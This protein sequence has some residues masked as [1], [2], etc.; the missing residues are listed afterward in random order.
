MALKAGFICIFSFFR[1]FY[2]THSPNIYRLVKSLKKSSVF[3]T[4]Q[5]SQTRTLTTKRVHNTDHRENITDFHIQI[6]HGTKPQTAV[7]ATEEEENSGWSKDARTPFLANLR[8]RFS[9]LVQDE[10]F[11]SEDQDNDQVKDDNLMTVLLKMPFQDT[12][13]IAEDVSRLPHI[14]LHSESAEQHQNVEHE[15][16]CDGR[17]LLLLDPKDVARSKPIFQDQW[18]R[19]QPILIAHSSQHLKQRLWTPESFQ[20][21]FGHLKHTLINCLTGNTVPN[22]ELKKFWVGFERVTKRLKD[23]KGTPMLL[24]LKDWP[25]KEDLAVYMPERFED[26]INSFPM[27]EYTLR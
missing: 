8:S 14:V 22:A 16:L 26:L 9:D 23:K 7:A 10:E 1:H 11:E 18:L 17:L 12:S 20:K 19:G 13:S 24:K 3:Q 25:P 2:S 21:D 15:W 4:D 5:S 27:P 6:C